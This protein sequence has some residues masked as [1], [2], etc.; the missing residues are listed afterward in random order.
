M[1]GEDAVSEPEPLV[2]DDL[3][4]REQQRGRQRALEDRA[5]ASC[6]GSQ[7]GVTGCEEEVGAREM[8]LRMPPVMKADAAVSLVPCRRSGFCVAVGASPNSA[9]SAGSAAN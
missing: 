9:A 3:A 6:V 7:R 5:L 2:E 1:T 4:D 8:P